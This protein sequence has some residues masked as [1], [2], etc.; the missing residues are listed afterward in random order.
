ML[1]LVHINLFKAQKK[2]DFP[3]LM[4]SVYKSNYKKL[5]I[6]FILMSMTNTLCYETLCGSFIHNT[7]S[8]KAN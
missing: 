8:Y 7:K 3:I 5:L 2:N 6:S 1:I 4:S